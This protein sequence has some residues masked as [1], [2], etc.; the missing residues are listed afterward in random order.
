M[1]LPYREGK[2][3]Q[4]KTEDVTFGKLK[5]GIYRVKIT[6][7]N[8]KF[9]NVFNFSD[10]NHYV[11]SLLDAIYKHK[12]YFGLTLTLLEPDE[13]HNYNAMLYEYDD[14]MSG[15]IIFSNWLSDMMKVKKQI[16]KNRLLK[17]LISSIWG[18]L[19]GF[20]NVY[21][22]EQ[23]V[24]K[25]DFTR[26]N[27]TEDSDYKLRNITDNELYKLVKSDDAYM[28]NLA[29]IK[30]FMVGLGRK[31]LFNLIMDNN[32]IDNVIAIHTDR[33]TLNKKYDF[34]KKHKYYPEPEAKSTG[35]IIFENPLHYRH[36]C[37]K[38]ETVYRFKDG[39]DCEM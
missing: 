8:S 27:S 6:Y 11:S 18:C 9:T 35:N 2:I 16:P 24:S 23:N 17:H 29:R 1:Q 26:I 38:C 4:L 12:D 15:K 25:L 7:T 32:L 5:F 20:K 22:E 3:Y 10:S 33:I 14:L 21:F 28:H 30:P 13:E 34:S 36:V 31:K 39:H 19:L 37:E